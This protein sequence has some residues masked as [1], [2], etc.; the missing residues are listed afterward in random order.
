MEVKREFCS[1]GC[2]SK[3][4][5]YSGV[6][7]RCR[8]GRSSNYN[9]GRKEISVDEMQRRESLAEVYLDMKEGWPYPD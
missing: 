9:K 8:S 2:G 1:R 6:C 3:T 5:D 4:E 7:S